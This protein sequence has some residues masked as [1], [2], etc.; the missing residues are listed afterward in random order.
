M[1][2]RQPRYIAPADPNVV[3]EKM[4]EAT[5]KFAE[6]A[7]RKQQ[8][9]YCRENPEACKGNDDDKD[10]SG[11]SKTESKETNI[12]NTLKPPMPSTTN[13]KGKK[14]NFGTGVQGT[15]GGIHNTNYDPT[16]PSTW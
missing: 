6:T 7:E 16:D 5:D 9:K 15:V 14:V 11:S 8:E 13:T 1:S 3:G 12:A 2:Y 10:D 4:M